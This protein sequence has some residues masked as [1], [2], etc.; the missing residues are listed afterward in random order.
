MSSF[1]SHLIA[2][3]ATTGGDEAPAQ[4]PY[5]FSVVLGGPLYQIVRRAHLAGVALEL[6]RRRIVV[7]SL[8]AW[9]P[10]LILSAL[11]GRAWGDAVTVP[12]L[13]D[14]E[15]HT[16]FL[17]TLPLL[18]MAELV[19][20][21]RMRPVVRQ[22]LERDLIPPAS[23][24]RFTAAAAS[25]VR[26][27]NSV[28]AEVFLVVLVYA[29]ALYVWPRYVALDV[30]TWYAMPTK[31]GRQLFPAGWWFVYVSNPVAQ[32]ILVRWYFRLFVW[33]RFLWQVARCELSLVPTHPDRV[34]GLGFLSG[35]VVAF[36]PLLVAHGTLLA[37][38][39]AN[40]ILFQGSTL[41]EFKVEIVVV[42]AFLLLL[43]LGPLL[44]FMPHLARARRIGLREYGTLAQRYVREFDEKWIRGSPPSGEPLVGSAD[45][46]SLADLGNA[47]DIVRSMRT[48]P[49]TRDTV[50]QLAVITLVPVA[51]LL[52]TMVSLE[53]L[54]KRLLQI[55]L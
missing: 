33:M 24:A 34:G 37:A 8:F 53:E 49:F 30:P 5:D 43:V 46:Q 20:H 38:L 14:I 35:T 19:V 10:L 17:L 23:R 13:L 28:T 7:I 32:F 26:L 9:L 44:L 52:L 45:I 12:F 42:V 55:V 41:P 11:S 31:G 4:D 3:S 27:R 22:F 40:R 21:Q 54:L 39:I 47:Y 29:M 36:A 51:P 6:L 2:D 16:R 25:A 15:V 48:V 50:L 1:Q 18:I